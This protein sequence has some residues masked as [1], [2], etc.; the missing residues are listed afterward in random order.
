MTQKRGVAG[1]LMLGLAGLWTLAASAWVYAA[2]SPVGITPPPPVTAKAAILIDAGSGKV[3]WEKNAQERLPMASVT[4]LMTLVLAFRAIQHGKASMRDLVPVSMEA[5]RTGGSQIW[6][7]PG[8]RLTLRQMLTAIAVGSANDAAVAVGEYL[9]GSTGQFVQL[10]NQEAARLG[11]RDT[12][13]SNPH[14]LPALDHYSTAHDLALLAERA[15]KTPGLL[16]LTSMWQD[17]TI[18]NGKGGYLWLVNHNRLLRAYPGADGLKTGYTQAAGFCLVATAL[19]GQTRMIA[20]VL[21]APTSKDRFDDAASLMSW[22]FSNFKS[23][24]VVR[25]R[26]VLGEVRVL[27]GSQKTVQAVAARALQVT[28]TRGESKTLNQSIQLLPEVGAPVASGQRLGTLTVSR[29]STTV[30]RVPLVAANPVR[31]V[32]VPELVWRY[33]WRILA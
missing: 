22:G 17:K 18:R 10:M 33:F 21:G 29:G 11:M 27:R 31:A 9:A 3:L 8:E 23:V 4:K 20:V 7:E 12:H 13:F 16:Q 1:L 32:G 19:R 26:D 6:L 25:Q 28:V 2:P 30:D 14:G 24:A 15:A 5:Y